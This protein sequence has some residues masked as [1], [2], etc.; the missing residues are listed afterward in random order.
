MA[1]ATKMAKSPAAQD[2]KEAKGHKEKTEKSS[3]QKRW[4]NNQTG[5]CVCIAH[6]CD[7]R[8][9]CGVHRGLTRRLP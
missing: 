6:V 7:R 5:R 2:S 9:F 4:L 1:L 3:R 8:R